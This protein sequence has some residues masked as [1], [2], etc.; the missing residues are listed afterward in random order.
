MHRQCDQP[1]AQGPP[2][3][4]GQDADA[5]NHQRPVDILPQRD[6]DK[7][8]WLERAEAAACG[9]LGRN[10]LGR[11]RRA[12]DGGEVARLWAAKAARIT[13][14]PASASATVRAT[15]SASVWASAW[16]AARSAPGEERTMILRPYTSSGG[17][18]KTGGGAKGSDIG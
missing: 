12:D 17:R 14:A 16:G 15:M 8:A 10:R 6:G 2:A 11:L 5:R 4:F 7:P 18:G 9:D 1:A 3:R 13:S